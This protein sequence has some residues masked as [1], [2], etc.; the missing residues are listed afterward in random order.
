MSIDIIYVFYHQ[1][2]VTVVKLVV[3]LSDKGFPNKIKVNVVK[4]IV[5]ENI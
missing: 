2:A 4:Q 3:K 1:L 5:L